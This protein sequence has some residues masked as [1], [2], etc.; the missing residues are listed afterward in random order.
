MEGLGEGPRARCVFLATGVRVWHAHPRSPAQRRPALDHEEV[1]ERAHPSGHVVL[2][3]GAEVSGARAN[4][5][6]RRA[7]AVVCMGRPFQTKTTFATRTAI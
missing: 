6:R 2:P 1:L 4:I 3:Q 7:T 5:R